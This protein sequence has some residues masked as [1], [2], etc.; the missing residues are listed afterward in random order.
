[1]EDQKEFSQSN[2]LDIFDP[3][4][5]LENSQSNEISELSKS[6][7]QLLKA[8]K[9]QEAKDSSAIES[10]VTTHD[11]LYKADLDVKDYIISA[12][13]KEVLNYREAIQ[14]GF[15]LVKDK[16]LL[17]NSVLK[18]IQERLEGNKAGFRTA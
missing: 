7:Y 3:T 14:K 6:G 12:S 13:T 4:K 9:V 1:M 5:E 8:N 10:I 2:E 11:E 15:Y 17:T 18:Q 16:G